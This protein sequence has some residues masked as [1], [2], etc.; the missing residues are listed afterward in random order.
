MTDNETR[1]VCLGRPARPRRARPRRPAPGDGRGR[2]RS[3][4]GA[5][6]SE[7]PGWLVACLSEFADRGVNLTRIESRPRK[8]GLGS[9]MFFADVEGRDTEPHVAAPSI[10]ALAAH[11][12]VLRIL[13]SFP[14][15][16]ARSRCSRRAPG[17]VYEDQATRAGQGD[18]LQFRAQ[19]MRR[20]STP[21]ANRV[22][23]A[24]AP[25][26]RA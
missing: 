10:A 17:A 7:A 21:S 9:Y 13:G 20:L 11:V 8:Q 6:G 5:P 24:T 4:S 18:Q 2:R 3:S 19:S 14:G 1:F 16:L 22:R 25:A 23:A 12:E 15:R 26:A